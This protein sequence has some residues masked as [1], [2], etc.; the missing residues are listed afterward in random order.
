MPLLDKSWRHYAG[1]HLSQGVD[2]LGQLGSAILGLI[3]PGADVKGMLETSQATADAT[4][5]GDPVGAFSNL[6]MTA[7]AI[8]MMFLPGSVKGI[9]NA[10]PTDEASRMARAKRMGFD[11]DTP[12]YHGTP[13]PEFSSFRVNPKKPHEPG[14]FFAKDPGLANEYAGYNRPDAP[15][16]YPKTGAVIPAVARGKQKVV[17][18]GGGKYGRPEAIQQAI[19]EGYDSVLLKNHYDVGGVGDQVVVFD[20]KNIRSRFAQFD[21]AKADSSDLLAGFAALMGAG[22]ILGLGAGN[23]QASPILGDR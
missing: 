2:N 21:P 4:R 16:P 23:A 19:A 12:L 18:F 3:G 14:V 10:L 15:F 22:G 6:G 13:D 9:K 17:D 8:P 20:P 11:V 5:R 1:P 7:A